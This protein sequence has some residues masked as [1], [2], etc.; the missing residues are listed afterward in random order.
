VAQ[1]VG[2]HGPPDDRGDVT[3]DEQCDRVRQE[4]LARS[5]QTV[6]IRRRRV[7]EEPLGIHRPTLDT[8]EAIARALGVRL[9]E[10]IEPKRRR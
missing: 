7:D 3:T 1:H 2:V 5:H 8:L 6:R 10:L 4:R 9:V